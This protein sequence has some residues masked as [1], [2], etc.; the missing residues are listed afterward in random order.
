MP[1]V[2]VLIAGYFCGVKCN[3]IVDSANLDRTFGDVDMLQGS[4]A[5][6]AR[7]YS[8]KF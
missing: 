5:S 8:D 1:A 2:S 4:G 6:K 7:S 3:E